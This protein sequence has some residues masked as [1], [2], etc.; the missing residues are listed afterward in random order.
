VRLPR[1]LCQRLV[2]SRTLHLGAGRTGYGPIPANEEWFERLRTETAALAADLPADCWVSTTILRGCSD[3][4]AAMR[5]LSEFCLDMSDA[6]AMLEA[7]AARVNELHW[8]VLRMHFE[9]IQPKLGGYGHIFG[10][11][12]LARPPCCRK[13]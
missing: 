8:R 9:T 2:R 13:T 4:L 11:G 1:S 12:R 6:P 10:F 5:G 3:V 7:A